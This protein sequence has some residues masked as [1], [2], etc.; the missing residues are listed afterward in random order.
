MAEF[1]CFLVDPLHEINVVFVEFALSINYGDDAWC[2]VVEQEG[3]HVWNIRKDARKVVLGDRQQIVVGGFALHCAVLWNE[4]WD[5]NQSDWCLYIWLIK[6]A[7]RPFAFA[8][9]TQPP[10]KGVEAQK[11]WT[12]CTAA[13]SLHIIVHI[14]SWCRCG[15]E[16]VLL[17][18][19]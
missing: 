3:L 14:H 11:I 1:L 18:D 7:Y 8:I 5:E 17:P 19:S 13:Q 12:Q 2:L 4:L 9:H 16:K 6:Y 10:P 15:L